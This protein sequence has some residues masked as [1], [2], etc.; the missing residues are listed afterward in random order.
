VPWAAAHRV[1]VCV[2]FSVL[3][4]NYFPPKKKYPN[5]IWNFA[6][7][8]NKYNTTYPMTS[9][10]KESKFSREIISNIFL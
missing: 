2:F 9:Y 3:S 4:F 6:M 10:E 5:T 1:I 7:K 8:T